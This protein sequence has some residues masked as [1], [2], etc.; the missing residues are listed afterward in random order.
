M[1]TAWITGAKGFIGRQLA[2]RLHCNGVEVAGIGHGVWRHDDAA[3]WGVINWINGDIVSSNF[4]RLR[5]LTG[6][7]DVIYHLAGGSSVGPSIETPAEDFSRTVDSSM[8]LLEWVRNHSNQTSLVFASS[9]AVY[10]ASHK[11]PIKES[12]EIIPFSPY[13]YHKRISELLFESYSRNYGLNSAVVRLFSVYGPELKKQLLWDLCNR[14][15]QFPD[16]MELFGSG[17]ET[18]DWLHVDDAVGYL[19]RA[20]TL[21]DSQGFTV[22]G[23]CGIATSVKDIVYCVRDAWA[24]DTAITFNGKQKEGDPHYLVADMSYGKNF[25]FLP[26]HNW[27]TGISEYVTWYK[28]ACLSDLK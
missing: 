3:Q 21:A 28:S 27:S 10:G 19:I 17:D 5:A 1:S 18:R 7:P 11:K 26:E 25:E 15:K 4:D 14:F 23:G 6:N 2:K 8:Q 12:D 20:A 16:E 22:N 24:L 13:G 9:A